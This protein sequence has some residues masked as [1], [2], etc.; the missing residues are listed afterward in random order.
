MKKARHLGVSMRIR[1]MG[2]SSR[3]KA[4]RHLLTLETLKFISEYLDDGNARMAAL[5]SGIPETYATRQGQWLKKHPM[6][7]AAL[8][9]DLDTREKQQIK[10]S[11]A[12]IER[13]MQN[14]KE[15]LG[16]E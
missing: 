11:L 14:C 7:I 16:I 5:R 1:Q 6:V 4:H 9:R 15:I 2:F 3:L 8:E 12:L 13:E 10:K